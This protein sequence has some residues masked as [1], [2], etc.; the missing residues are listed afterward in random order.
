MNS[1]AALKYLPVLLSLIAAV[2]LV[3]WSFSGREMPGT[4]APFQPTAQIKPS[5]KGASTVT[6]TAPSA[7]ELTRS[8]AQFTTFQKHPFTATREA[9]GFGWTLE[10]GKN[11]DVI[12]QLAHNELEFQR[13]ADETDRI[14]R[15]Q[16]IYHQDTMDAQI[17]RAKSTG[18]PIRQIV[19]PG[20]DGQEVQFE[21]TQTGLNPSGHS[22]SFAGRV[23]GKFDSMVTLAFKGGREA[24]TIISPSDKLYLVGEP[25]EP[26]ELVVKSIDPNT[27]VTGLCG[28]P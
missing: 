9:A 8:K 12:K 28:T 11:P 18:Q 6:V 13:M 27:Y 21:I 3:A 1:K 15:R 25:R 22:G 16:L 17:E 23:P 26:G 20:L 10:D 5:T 4:P 24:F 14:Y 19:L 2:A 7:S